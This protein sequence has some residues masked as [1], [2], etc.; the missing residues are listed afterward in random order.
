MSKRL[1]ILVPVYNVEKY[2]RP[3]FE[4]VFRQG[5]PEECYEIIVVNDCTPDRSMEQV[6]DLLSQHDNITIIN[7]D[8]QGLSVAR[9]IALDR[10]MGEYVLML[11]SDDLLIDGSLPL[12]LEKALESKAD[13][14]VADFQKLTDEEIEALPQ[15][16]AQPDI[17]WNEM[18]GKQAFLEVLNPRECYVWR[19]MYRRAFLQEHH[20]RFVPGIFYQDVPF[21][22]ECYLNA[23]RC[24]R[25]N[26]LL[27][28]YRQRGGSVQSKYTLRH[29][30]DFSIA[31]GKTWA[32][33]K[34][35]GIS[36]EED[37]KLQA[38]V[39][40]SFYAMMR[41][42]IYFLHSTNDRQQAM[43]FL[44]QNAPDLRFTDGRTQRI[45][46]LLYRFSPHLLMTVWSLRWKW[47]HRKTA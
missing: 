9:N 5:L 14:V 8:N 32:L 41:T 35:E 11:D 42:T 27:I 28:I 18:T 46:T 29:A 30:K 20:I 23:R 36:P 16:V 25:T 33:R 22:H 10:A 34:K 40:T 45:I 6:A 47:T 2:I 43:D 12:L 19:T 24:L 38:D 26:L 13:L 21:T 17:E 1:S 7:Q 39:F 3:F 31:I 4:S 37:K 15:S 44:T